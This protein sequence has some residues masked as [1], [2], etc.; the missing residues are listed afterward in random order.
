M[1]VPDQVPFNQYTASGSSDTFSYTFKVLGADQLVIKLD[2]VVQVSGFSVTGVGNDAGGTVVFTSNPAGGTIVEIIRSTPATRSTDY[3][4]NGDLAEEV[5]DADFDRAYMALQEMQEQV[6]RTMQLPRGSTGSLDLDE[7][8]SD[9]FLRVNSA[10]NAITQ[11]NVLTPS[12]SFTV[13]PFAETLLDDVSASAMRTTLSVISAADAQAG[14]VGR[15]VDIQVF[16]TAGTHTWNNPLNL[17]DASADAIVEIIIVSGGASGG[18]AANST[19]GNIAVGA[20]GGG[21]AYMHAIIAASRL[22]AT[23]TVTVGAG[24]AEVAN[25]AGNA[26]GTSRFS[27]SGSQYIRCTG[28]HPGTNL[29]NGNTIGLATGGLGGSVTW[30]GSYWTVLKVQN[31]QQGDLSRR[32][33]GTEVITGKGGDSLHG[34]GGTMAG[35]SVGFGAIGVGGGGSVGVGGG[36]VGV[37]GGG[38]VGVGGG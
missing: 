30:P 12:G 19:A 18:G 9:A 5:L 8:V 16:N 11:V 35:N 22:G 1:A 14:M 23:E 21:G 38:S 25:S 15:L 26:G 28:G 32:L 3:A 13:S 20:N 6:D 4:P 31:G 10:G 36:W 17:G 37:G 2:D 27:A 29:A 34:M 7:L 33:S 24:G